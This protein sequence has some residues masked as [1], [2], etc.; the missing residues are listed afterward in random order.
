MKKTIAAG[1]LIVGIDGSGPD[2]AALRWAARCGAEDGAALVLA[3][4]KDADSRE[5]SDRSLL[6]DAR[7]IID[8]EQPGISVETVS[9]VGPVWQALSDAADTDDAIIIG[10]G[11]SGLHRGRASGAL[12]IQLAMTARCAVAVIPD[13]D[14]RFRRGVVAGIGSHE[15]A[16]TVAAAASAEARRLGAPLTLVHGGCIENCTE[17]L[18]AAEQR[19]RGDGFDLSIRRRTSSAPAAD[20]LLDAALDKELLVLGR[21]SRTRSG[22]PIGVV[23]H[24][25]LMNP[26]S[27]LLLLAP[28]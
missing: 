25:A 10:T 13:I 23:T 5:H 2:T 3:N 1:R 22:A 28:A 6:D 21:A 27:P 12:S 8:A 19:L 16:V 15:N 11:K 4:V 20:A 7:A 14:L 24:T 17:G 9:L 18:D 26:T